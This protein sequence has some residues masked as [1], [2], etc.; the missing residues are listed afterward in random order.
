MIL[1]LPE[2]TIFTVGGTIILV[3]VL[4]ILWGIIYPKVE[5]N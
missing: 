3:L 5:D 1:G 4:L 2:L